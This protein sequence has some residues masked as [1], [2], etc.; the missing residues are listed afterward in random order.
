[1]LPEK[2]SKTIPREAKSKSK[3]SFQGLQNFFVNQR[4]HFRR[5]FSISDGALKVLFCI[6]KL[7]LIACIQRCNHIA[8]ANGIAG[9]FVQYDSRTEIQHVLLGLSARAE[10]NLAPLKNNFSAITL[11]ILKK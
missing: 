2:K 10:K 3:S 4:L 1:M 8:L 9:L 7:R 11:I 6:F 5:I